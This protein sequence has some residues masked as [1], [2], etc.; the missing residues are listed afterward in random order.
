MYRGL[1]QMVN[2]DGQENHDHGLLIG[3]IKS[4]IENIFYYHS[5]NRGFQTAHE[6]K[7]SSIPK[8]Q[9][10]D[11]RDYEPNIQNKLSL[12]RNIKQKTNVPP[13]IFDKS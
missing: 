3:K 12:K 2:N 4:Y 10:S 6:K 1:V 13:L 7:P 5:L 9:L 8:H 11:E